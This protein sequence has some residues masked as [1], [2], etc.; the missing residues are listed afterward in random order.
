MS[1]PFRRRCSFLRRSYT[2]ELQILQSYHAELQLRFDD[3]IAGNRI[4]KV[5]VF[6][7][8][9][10]QSFRH[11]ILCILCMDTAPPSPLNGSPLTHN[12]VSAT[13]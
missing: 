3:Q 13:S 10:G 4:L 9:R 8:S 7:I 6:K 5:P 12:V 1:L 2:I 11:P